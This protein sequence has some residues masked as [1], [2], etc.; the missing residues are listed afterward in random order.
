MTEKELLEH[1]FEGHSIEA[2]TPAHMA[3]H[4]LSRRALRI[5]SEING[6]YHTPD[7]LRGLMSEL[8][9]RKLDN[10]FGLFPPFYTDCGLNTIIGERTF[11]NMGCKFQDWGGIAIGSDCLIGHNCT[12]CTVNH[13]QDPDR[14]GDMAFHRVTI[15]DK[16]WIGANVTI[17]PGV[18]IGRGAI[19]AAGAVVTKDVAPMTVVAGVPARTIKIIE[20]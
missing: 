18:T 1:T 15:A 6:A 16:V 5:T 4:G 19:V 13:A 2:G 7:E 14:R 3:M 11:I 10:S 17:L 8:T 12:I 20:Q 9:G